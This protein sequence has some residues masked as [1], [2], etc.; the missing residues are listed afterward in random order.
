[1]VRVNL[2]RP[3]HLA[4]QHLVAEYAEILMVFTYAK[5]HPSIEKVPKKYCLGTGHIRFF[6]NKLAYLKQRHEAL[7][8]EMRRR[9]FTPRLSASFRGIKKQLIKNWKPTAADK[10]II[11][12]RLIWKLK[13]KTG[14]Y[15]YY[16]KNKATAFF[17]Q[18][19][20]TA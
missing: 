20:K 15:K 8:K 11:K 1:M 7:K 6:K 2:I 18:M 5:K 9:G 13:K 14:F 10:R 16:G 3:S 19:I 17:I 4:D 12:Q